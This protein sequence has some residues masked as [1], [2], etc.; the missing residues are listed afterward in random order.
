MEEKMHLMPCNL[1]WVADTCDVFINWQVFA[2]KR[3]VHTFSINGGIGGY[4][5]DFCSSQTDDKAQHI[6]LSEFDSNNSL[7]DTYITYTH[8]IFTKKQHVVKENNILRT[9]NVTK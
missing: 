5:V 3:R 1:N 7:F 4:Q 9:Y 2:T 8:Q 6:C